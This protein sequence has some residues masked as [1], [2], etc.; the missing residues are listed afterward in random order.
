MVVIRL[1]RTGKT[2]A[3]YYRVTV[4][5]KRRWRDGKFLAKVGWY[6]PRTDDAKSR[7]K[8]DIPQIDEWIKKGAQPSTTVA[9]LIK[10]YK[11]LNA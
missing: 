4:A 9:K 5:D 10:D 2:N 7:I 11:K 8:L 6:N 3:A 1:A